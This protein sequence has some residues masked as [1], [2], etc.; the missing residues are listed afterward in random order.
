MTRGNEKVRRPLDF[1]H[2]PTFRL[3]EPAGPAGTLSAARNSLRSRLCRKALR[4]P[5][6]SPFGN[7]ERRG[8]R[9][10][11][12]LF[13]LLVR[14]CNTKHG[15]TCLFILQNQHLKNCTHKTKSTLFFFGYISRQHSIEFWLGVVDRP[16][17]RTHE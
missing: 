1:T 13:V 11:Y 3:T 5:A 6:Q 2:Q 17:E 9:S 8:N 4:S 12:G 16:L 7:V 14:S 15:L 10:S